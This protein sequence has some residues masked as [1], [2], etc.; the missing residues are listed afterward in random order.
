MTARRTPKTSA[1]PAKRSRSTAGDAGKRPRRPR[2]TKAPPEAVARVDLWRAGLLDSPTAAPPALDA[3]DL[4]GPSAG[5]SI[6][7]IPPGLFDDDVRRFVV[8]VVRSVYRME[9]PKN[10]LMR[11]VYRVLAR[12]ADQG[13]SANAEAV[14]LGILLAKAKLAGERIETKTQ[15]LAPE[16]SVRHATLL[17]IRKVALEE[18]GR[19]EPDTGQ[20]GNLF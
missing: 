2:Q 1:K 7:Q 9:P 5:Y 14:V 13:V 6:I 15:Q 10:P 17:K 8:A 20:P 3:T 4:Y 18:L 11:A 19:L 12:L 16:A